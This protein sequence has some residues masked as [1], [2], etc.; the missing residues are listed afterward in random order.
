MHRSAIDIK[1]F[2]SMATLS[3]C[4]S[5]LQWQMRGECQCARTGS[6]HEENCRPHQIIANNTLSLSL[7]QLLPK[8]ADLFMPRLIPRITKGWPSRTLFCYALSLHFAHSRYNSSFVLQLCLNCPG[9]R[10]LFPPFCSRSAE[11]FEDKKPHVWRSR[12][13]PIKTTIEK[14]KRKIDLSHLYRSIFIFGNS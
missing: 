11:E 9:E 5:R 2:R 1:T 14:Q 7:F 8:P 3:L 12:S 13:F 4:P 10:K 6:K